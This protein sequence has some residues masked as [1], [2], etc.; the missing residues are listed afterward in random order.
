MARAAFSEEGW[1]D[2]QG[3]L[4]YCQPPRK[5]L[6]KGPPPSVALAEQCNVVEGE[7]H[8]ALVVTAQNRNT[9]KEV[10][11]PE[12]KMLCFGV[13]VARSHF[14]EQCRPH[15]CFCV[16]ANPQMFHLAEE[17]LSYVLC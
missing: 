11:L 5:P 9:G 6:L 16:N 8:F 1:W 14:H 17:H 7:V 4:N 15:L 13:A 12:G 3:E 10:G 2:E